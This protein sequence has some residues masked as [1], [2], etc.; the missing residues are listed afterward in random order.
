ML[1]Y[2]VDILEGYGNKL[3]EV[4]ATGTRMALAVVVASGTMML[5]AGNVAGT[6]VVTTESGEVAKQGVPVSLE[7]RVV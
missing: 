7:R 5:F 4:E 3:A 6:R 1:K 2:I